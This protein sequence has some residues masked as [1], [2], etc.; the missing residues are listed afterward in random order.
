MVCG[1]AE[2]HPAAR[3]SR[4]NLVTVSILSPGARRDGAAV[5]DT[6]VNEREAPIGAAT[7]VPSGS[8]AFAGRALS[9]RSRPRGYPGRGSGY[10]GKRSLAEG[11]AAGSTVP[12][13]RRRDKTPSAKIPP[14]SSRSEPGSGEA[15]N[16]GGSN[17][18][19]P[20][21]RSVTPSAELFVCG[22]HPLDAPS[23][24]RKLLLNTKA[25]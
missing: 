1:C 16:F 7:G 19:C 24:I 22:T 5:R 13:K 2:R 14:P 11:P 15:V 3:R 12:H 4:V 6:E 17:S 18:G 21:K 23:V 8:G 10:R 9:E 25:K 20:L